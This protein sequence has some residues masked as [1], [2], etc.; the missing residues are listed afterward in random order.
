MT[1][2]KILIVLAFLGMGL[3]QSYSQ[4]YTFKTSGVSVMSQD[5]KGDWGEWSN[6]KNVTFIVK[7]DTNMNKILIY[8]EEI[9]YFDIVEYLPQ[10]ENDTD[11]IYSFACKYNGGEECTLSI[12][13]R[14]NQ[15]NR[16][17]LYVN[18]SDQIIVYNMANFK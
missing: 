17:Q 14:K 15:D 8:S 9:Q 11:S 4:T 10:E 3:H 1:K 2:I 12:I 16:K 18:Y 5:K 13:T 7:L 6:L